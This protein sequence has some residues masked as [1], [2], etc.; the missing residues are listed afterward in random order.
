[1]ICES[2][3]RFVQHIVDGL[4]MR[5]CVN[6]LGITFMYIHLTNNDLSMTSCSNCSSHVFPWT[7]LVALSHRERGSITSWITATARNE[8]TILDM[9]PNDLPSPK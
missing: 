7:R 5:G 1:M 9:A 2:S 3:V 4:G 6:M 8:F